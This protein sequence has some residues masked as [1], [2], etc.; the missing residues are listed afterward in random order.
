MLIN[1]LKRKFR[2][3]FSDEIF[4]QK[5]EGSTL[6][7]VTFPMHVMKPLGFQWL[8][9]FFAYMKNNADIV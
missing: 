8:K 2:E 6:S 9:D 1:R 7:P 3:W 5:E 4:N